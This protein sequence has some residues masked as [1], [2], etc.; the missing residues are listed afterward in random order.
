MSRIKLSSEQILAA[1]SAGPKTITELAGGSL[2]Y[3]V[4]RPIRAAIDAMLAAGQVRVVALGRARCFVAAEWRVTDAWLVEYFGRSMRREGS[5][6]VWEGSWDQWHRAVL[7][8]DG[9]RYD[10][11]RELYRIRTGKTLGKRDTVRAKCEHETCM[12][13]A[14]QVVHKAKGSNGPKH[15]VA[16]KAKL[17]AAKR[18]RS[19][20]GSDL[21]AQVKASTKSYKQIAR[22]TGMKLSTVGAIKGGRLW[23]DYSSPWA[24][25][26]A[27]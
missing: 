21:V 2:A 27:R 24:G 23:K 10:V 22:E 18:D 8:I 4:R 9:G 13:P 5:H 16:T 26:W 1:L 19:K 20:Y 12:A 15:S 11:R 17:A 3:S 7:R 14:C 6:L 25:L